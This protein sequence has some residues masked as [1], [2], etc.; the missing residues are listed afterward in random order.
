MKN[1]SKRGSVL[2]LVTLLTLVLAAFAIVALRSVSR[3]VQASAT[4]LTRAQAAETADTVNRMSSRY[5]GE[6]YENVWVHM[7]APSSGAECFGPNAYADRAECLAAT[8]DPDPLAQSSDITGLY[9]GSVDAETTRLVTM[10]GP[11]AQYDEDRFSH[12]LGFTAA[13]S[14]SGLFTDGQAAA[15]SFESL[16]DT[17]YRM[18]IRDPYD[19]PPPMG[20]QAN[21]TLCSKKLSFYSEALVGI[22]LADWNGPSNT[23]QSRVGT[24]GVIGPVE[25]GT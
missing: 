23:A 19:F 3:T 24:Q 25:C 1:P 8:G 15:S 14:E 22:N 21:G 20:E 10:L 6:R 9:G 18:M 2:V 5:V 11:H 4:Y 7:Q 16:K 17:S 12:F 13:I